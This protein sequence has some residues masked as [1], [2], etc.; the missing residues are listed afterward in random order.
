L[1]S[2]SQVLIEAIKFWNGPYLP[3][4]LPIFAAVD[5]AS[6]DA[7]FDAFFRDLIS[8]FPVFEAG[9]LLKIAE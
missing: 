4:E 2:R 5:T 3:L 1:Y 6:E 8:I 7:L 9:V